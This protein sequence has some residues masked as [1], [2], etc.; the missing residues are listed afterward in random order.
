MPD[1]AALAGLFGN[2]K[3]VF[4]FVAGTTGS[5][6]GFTSD[7]GA[8]GQFEQLFSGSSAGTGAEAV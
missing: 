6:S 8:V 2:I 3:S 4:D 7:K 1:F 5:L